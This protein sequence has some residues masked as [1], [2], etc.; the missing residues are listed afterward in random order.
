VDDDPQDFDFSTTN[1]TP[2]TFTLDDDGVGPNQRAFAALPPEDV[3]GHRGRRF[4]RVATDRHRLCGWR[5][6]TSDTGRMATIGLDPA[7]MLT[8]TFTN[9][10]L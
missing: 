2:A 8:C 9:S 6:D 7:K 1:L 4:A 10:L 3:H 5:P